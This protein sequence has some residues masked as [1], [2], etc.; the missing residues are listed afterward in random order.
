MNSYRILVAFLFFLPAIV[1]SQYT[2]LHFEHITVEN[3]LSNNF[4]YCTFQD[5]E[6][7]IW[8]G[9]E[10]GLNRWDG[11]NFKIFKN[12]P[13]DSTTISNNRIFGITEDK[14]GVLW[15][16]TAFGLNKYI[17]DTDSFKRMKYFLLLLWHQY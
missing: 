11:N 12:N 3:G 6:G 2:N 16:S 1:I 14:D 13:N 7:Y 10:N 15:I 8:F 17:K 9:T 5:K 4:C